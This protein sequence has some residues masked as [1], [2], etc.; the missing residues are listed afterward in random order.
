MSTT[1][2][3]QFTEWLYEYSP[4]GNRK[5]LL[6]KFKDPDLQSAFL[7]DMGLPDDTEIWREENE[8][9]KCICT[10]AQKLTG[11]G[12]EACNPHKALE[13]A[14]DTIDAQRSEI[15]TLRQQLSEAN[16]TIAE[17]RKALGWV[18]VEDKLPEPERDVLCIGHL[19]NPPF[20]AALFEGR[21]ESFIDGG[22]KSFDVNYWMPLPPPPNTT[23]DNQP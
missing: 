9:D 23:K 12:C 1:I 15:E 18:N 3:D 17:L 13:Y 22:E 8:M 2:E 16:A 21:W 6:E 7:R 19:F 11:D 10:F 4:I 5:T 20:V 14:K